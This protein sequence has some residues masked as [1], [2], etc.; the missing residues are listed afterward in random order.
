MSV[1]LKTEADAIRTMRAGTYTLLELYVH[2]AATAD[3]ARDRGLEPPDAAHPTD[4]VWRRRARGV[5]Q[6]LRASGNAQRV[7]ASV[8]ALRGTRDHPQQLVLIARGGTLAQIELLL[9]DAVELLG[10]LEEPADLVLCDPPYGLARGTSASSAQRVYRRNHRQVV[11]GYMDVPAEGYKEFT[12]RWVAAAARALRPAGQLVAITGPQ[13]AALVQYAAEDSGL[14]W[15]NSIPAY[16]EFALRTTRRF[17][18]SH[19]KVT[20]MC[21]GRQQD[22]R[23]VFNVP[24]DLPKARSGIDYPLDWWPE[25]G[26]ADRPGLLRY[27]NSLPLRLVLRAIEACSNR[28]ELVV[29]PCVGSG[30]TAIAARRLGRRC[31]AAD[32]NPKALRFAAARLLY[33][34]AWPEEREPTLFGSLAA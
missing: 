2:V 9:K 11:G 26:R 22:R 27:D 19:W 25:N 21:R 32:T 6:T 17:A 5:L 24:Q 4:R 31:I 7:A 29:D 34:H 20:I 3:I 23:R 15:V 14:E 30:T 8:W 33:E 13:Q 18:C 12:F 1:G 10:E 28:G 16:R